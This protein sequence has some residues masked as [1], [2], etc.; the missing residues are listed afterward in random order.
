LNPLEAAQQN[1]DLRQ[2]Q[3]CLEGLEP[4]KREIVLLAYYTGL[5]RDEIAQRFGHP[6]GT[7]KVWLHRSLAQLRKC[8]GS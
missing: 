6:V 3:D 8:L 1:A 2:L 4:Q 7:I 5:S